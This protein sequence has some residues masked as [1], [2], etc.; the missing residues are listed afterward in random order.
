[1]KSVFVL[2]F[3]VLSV[4][5][6]FTTA[7]NIP[8]NGKSLEIKNKF[9][10]FISND[11]KSAN[12]GTHCA[13]CTIVLS[14]VNQYSGIHNKSIEDSLDE[15]CSFFPDE[16]G[17]LCTWLVNTYGEQIISYFDQYQNADDVCHAMNV[18]TSPTCRLFTSAP[19]KFYNPDHV[20]EE[21]NKEEPKVGGSPW[22]WIQELIKIFSSE[23]LP[24]QD[25]DGDHHSLEATFRGYNWRGKDCNDFD[26]SSYPGTIE[27]T[28]DANVDKN[29][30]GI[31]GVNNQSQSYEEL[32]CSNSGAMGV[33][34]SGDSAGAHF[35]IPPQWMTARDINSTTYKG[36]IDVLETEVDWPMRSTYTGWDTSV[37]NVDSMYLRMRERNL[38]NHRDY[39][40]LGVNGASSSSTRTIIQTIN[41]NQNTDKPVLLFLELIGNDVC[42]GHHDYDSMATVEEFGENI[43][44][45]LNYL[46]T[47]LPKGSHVVFVGLADGRVLWDSLWNRTHPLGC[48]YEEVYD[49]LNCIQVSPCWG[50]M[51]PNETIR[52]YTSN[53]A[54][55]LSLVYNQ[56][57]KNYTF[58]NFDM[59]YYDFPFATINEM[60]VAQ[61]GQTYDL[62]E[63]IDGFHP[64][65]IANY[66][67]AGVF[68]NQLA[69]DKPEWLGE[70]NQ[71]NTQIQTIFGNQGGYV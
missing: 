40:N 15:L 55:Q 50:W 13:A 51:N 24:I 14:L 4:L 28:S 39:Q 48:T 25:F 62:I 56:L 60:W 68:Y 12:G 61:G 67:M 5:I 2:L 20:H 6:N 49:F 65:Q 35:S 69:Q 46:E 54:A 17:S 27:G 29:C 36:M 31:F 11:V 23:H 7:V 42:S 44:T 45:I 21:Y 63:P 9:Q 38:C 70:I 64:N 41:R 19:S 37:P 34:V 53:R 26:K 22:A 66:L 30:N 52:D 1:M 58:N 71:Y 8:V 10:E 3:I 16:A 43:L 32:F 47:T 18:C 59:I 33:I 57:I